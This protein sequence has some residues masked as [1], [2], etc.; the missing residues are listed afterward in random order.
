MQCSW[1]KVGG[2][3]EREG[4]HL[5]GNFVCMCVRDWGRE[6]NLNDLVKNRVYGSVKRQKG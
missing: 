6:E 1:K 2:K 3:R 4:D 5:K